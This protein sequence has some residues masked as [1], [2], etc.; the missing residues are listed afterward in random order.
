MEVSGVYAA[1]CQGLLIDYVL[2]HPHYLGRRH[3]YMSSR[4]E[5][6]LPW[7]VVSVIAVLA[8]IMALVFINLIRPDVFGS[9]STEAKPAPAQTTDAPPAVPLP[10][11]STPAP[12]SVPASDPGPTSTIPV[13]QW[14]VSVEFPQA[15]G[16]AEYQISGDVVTFPTTLAEQLPAKCGNT[17]E[18][19]G[20]SR[21]ESKDAQNTHRVGDFYYGIES[22]VD[23]CQ[24]NSD[25]FNKIMGLY[26]AAL[27][28]V[29]AI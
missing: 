8:I 1:I 9:G 4:R 20:L 28:S 26:G 2:N 24:A 27:N 14:G 10:R 18:G 7:I 3:I 25:L 22:P 17:A 16:P 23:S 13:T 21:S 11:P 19:W 5:V 15:L 12:T 29:S 6:A